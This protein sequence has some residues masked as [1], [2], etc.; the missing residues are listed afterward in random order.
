MDISDIKLTTKEIADLFRLTETRV[1]Q[2]AKKKIIP[3]LGRGEFEL[4]PAAQSY[5]QYL[6]GQITG[7]VIADTSELEMRKLAAEAQERE[8]KAKMAQLNLSV[9]QGDLHES[10]VV[11]QFM[12]DV[13]IACRQ[14]MLAIP[15]RATGLLVG[16]KDQTEIASILRELLQ[17]ALESLADLDPAK[18]TELNEKYVPPRSEENAL[19]SEER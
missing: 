1:Q 12:T 19:P 13:I 7:A 2:L 9:M 3:K 17:E 16:K 14:R 11:E 5:I 10:R 4:K 8:A 15:S 18:L 6:Q